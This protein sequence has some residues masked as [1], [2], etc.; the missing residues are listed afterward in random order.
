ML[1]GSRFIILTNTGDNGSANTGGYSECGSA[2]NGSADGSKADNGA[3]C[4]G[5]GGSSGDG[6]DD[7]NDGTADISAGEPFLLKS[8]R[9]G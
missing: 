6:K 9:I 2:G 8:R 3:V 5:R 1:F 7:D 4:N